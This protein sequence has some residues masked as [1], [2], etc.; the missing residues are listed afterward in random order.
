MA[1]NGNVAMPA[2]AQLRFYIGDPAH[3]GIP[4][5]PDQL[6]PVM[7]GCGRTEELAITWN[8]APK[9]TTTVWVVV[10]PL[11]TIAESD[12]SDNRLSAAF[13]VGP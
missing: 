2:A 4:I 7:N 3:G 13:T 10:D 6:L 9:G 8:N 12:E 11:Y 5:G 1:N